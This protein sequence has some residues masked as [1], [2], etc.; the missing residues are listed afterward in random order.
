M[1][2]VDFQRSPQG[3]RVTLFVFLPG[4]GDTVRSFETEGFLQVVRREFPDAD[5][6]GV[7]AHQG[8][9]LDHT[10]LTRLREDVV[11]PAREQGYRD[12]WLIGVSMGGLGTILYDTAYPGELRGILAL[13]PYLG[14]PALLREIRDAGGL[15]GWRPGTVADDDTDRFIWSK[16]KVYQDRDRSLGRV[17]LGCG[18]LD[19]FY[20]TDRFLGALLPAGQVFTAPGGHDWPTWRVLGERM[21][22]TIGSSGSGAARPAR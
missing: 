11:T 18:T 17:Y 2:T 4:L 13:A 1:K 20:D 21:L 6:I 12:I 5:L 8:Y 9:Y 3:G 16:I 22:K 10:I 7:E 15:A 19:R 14:G